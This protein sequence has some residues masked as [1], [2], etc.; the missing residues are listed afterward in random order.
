MTINKKNLIIC[1]VLVALLFAFLSAVMSVR[2]IKRDTAIAANV[3]MNQIDHVTD[4]AMKTTKKTAL[5]ASEPCQEIMDKMA[6]AGALTSYIRSTG[7]IQDDVL[8]CSSVTGDNTQSIT[9][10]YGV[11]I[12]PGFDKPNILTLTGTRSTPIHPVIIYALN[13]GDNFTAFSTIDAQYFTDL[14]D[15]L[16]DKNNSVLSLKFNGGPD[17]TGMNKIDKNIKYSLEEFSSKKNQVK[18]RVYTPIMTFV[19]SFLK[20][21]FLLTPLFILICLALYYFWRSWQLR[22]MSLVDEIRKAIR[23]GEFSVSYQPVVATHTGHCTGAE[24]LM[25]WY[26][27][28][29]RTISPAVFITAAEEEGVI[30]EL[31]QHLFQLLERDLQVLQVDSPFH[32]GVNISALHLNHKDFINDVLNLWLLLDDSFRLV[33]EITERS[34]IDNTEEAS[35]KLNELRNKGCQVAV[36]DFGT[37]YCSLGLLHSLPVDYLKIDKSFIDTLTS[38]DTE[39]PVLDTIIGLSKRLGMSTIAEGV[40]TTYQVD[41]LKEKNVS[42][43]QGFYYAK[44][45]NIKDFHQWYMENK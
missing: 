20:D 18:I 12:K 43:I 13:A 8:I 10:I 4:I 30:V 27:K 24:A 17:I 5:M 41:Y 16:D 2:Q 25:R 14:M 31:S 7:L 3:L 38:A 22:K 33:L 23:D 15:A 11:R 35:V 29:G 44:P 34:F 6:I 32:L 37:G 28:D 39:T 36:D 21:I 26:R 9:S 40:S 42:Y 19:Q 1:I 45:M